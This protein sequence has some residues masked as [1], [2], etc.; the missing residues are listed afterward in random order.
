[1]RRPTAARVA[2]EQKPKTG[3]LARF[4]YAWMGAARRP[5]AEVLPLLLRPE[6]L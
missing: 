2:V 3:H 1:M 5:M 4:F 6:S